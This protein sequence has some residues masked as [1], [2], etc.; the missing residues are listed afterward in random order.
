MS[1]LAC[2]EPSLKSA[3]FMAVVTLALRYKN[4]NLVTMVLIVKCRMLIS[5]L[6]KELLR[7]LFKENLFPFG[8]IILLL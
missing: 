1:G 7:G 3:S 8:L 5:I 6:F 2:S 4:N